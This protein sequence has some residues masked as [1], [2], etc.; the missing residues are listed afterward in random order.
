VQ[1]NA[2]VSGHFAKHSQFNFSF[3]TTATSFIA[4]S[5]LCSFMF[6]CVAPSITTANV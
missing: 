4:Q 1:N 6:L 3:P 2:L 5:N